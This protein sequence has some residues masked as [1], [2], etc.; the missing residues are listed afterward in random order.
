MIEI[1]FPWCLTDVQDWQICWECC[2]GTLVLAWLGSNLTRVEIACHSTEG[3]VTWSDWKL[4]D[5]AARTWPH[6]VCACLRAWGR[7]W[8]FTTFLRLCDCIFFFP[9][10]TQCWKVSEFRLRLVFITVYQ[11][12]LV[13]LLEEWTHSSHW[14]LTIRG[15]DATRSTWRFWAAKWAYVTL[16]PPLF[17]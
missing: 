9:A 4:A 15:L 1:H 17:F 6:L 8:G 2:K 5:S 11:R 16:L 13:Q 12:G 7:S 3:L 14:F 10:A